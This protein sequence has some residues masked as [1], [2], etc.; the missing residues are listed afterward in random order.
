MAN[1]L[2]VTA[3]P[4]LARSRST[5]SSHFSFFSLPSSSSGLSKLQAS[6]T[7]AGSFYV[8]EVKEPSIIAKSNMHALR[9]A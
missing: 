8:R 1:N 2:L 7:F 6:P 3:H 4:T 5:N 9:L